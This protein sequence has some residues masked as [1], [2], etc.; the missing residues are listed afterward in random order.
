VLYEMATGHSPFR[1]DTSGTIFDAILNKPPTPPF[2]F[3]PDLPPQLEAVIS[4]ALQK[5]RE[6][7][8]QIAAEMKADLK[9]LKQETESRTIPAIEQKASTGKSRR[10]ALWTGLALLVLAGIVWTVRDRLVPRP[11]PF[12]RIGITQV[13]R[14]GRVSMAVVS[15]DGKYVAYIR[16]EGPGGGWW[17]TIAEQSLWVRQVA[18][19]DVQ[20]IGPSAVTYEGLTFSRDGDYLY[21]VRRT[22]AESGLGILF[23]M[24]TLGGTLRKVLSDVDSAVTLSPD[25]TQFAFVRDAG[26]KPESALLVANEDGS[27][28][29]QVAVLESPDRFEDVAWSPRGATL[30]AI[31]SHRVTGASFQRLVE[32]AAAGGPERSI[33]SEHWASTS[34]LTWMSD[35]RAVIVSAQVPGG[36]FE[37]FRVSLDHG[38]VRKIT[39]Q[40]TAF[41]ANLGVS[42]SADSRTIA[43]VQQNIAVDLWVGTTGEPDSFRPITTG[44]ISAWGAWIPG[45]KLVYSNYAGEG[46]VW[47]SSADGTGSTQ[48]A[49]GTLYNI[50]C[51]RVSP[52][53]RYIVF[54][55]WKTGTPHLWSMESDGGNP[56]QITDSAGDGSLSDVSA[57]SKWVIFSKTG[58][59]RGIW[60]VPIEGGDSVRLTEVS[61]MSPVVSWDGKMIAYHDFTGSSAKVAIMPFAGGP[62]IKTFGIPGFAPIRWTAD[63]TGI[64][65]IDTKAGVSNIW[66]QPISGAEPRQITRFSSDQINYFDL[67]RDGKRLV[68]DRFQSNADVVLI[69][70]VR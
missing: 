48:V 6:I 54:T 58:P 3:N 70:D 32:I 38:E 4:K 37:L 12:Q 51:F 56:K 67:S 25:G 61:S 69:R 55:S 41:F 30:A 35:G 17:Q 68:L 59:E 62:P 27:G 34:G 11:E 8:Y 36:P 50:G 10:R 44:G 47:V 15:P 52:N 9:R 45:E 18:G 16:S 65:Y 46:S 24:P 31:V 63:G 5:D 23:K 26:P 29:H 42:V 22:A 13:T 14:S 1:G 66:L 19:G 2:K 39:N 49:P 43:T 40:P 7:R 28:E 20:V 21:L 53:G 57:D 33:G 64:L 60:K